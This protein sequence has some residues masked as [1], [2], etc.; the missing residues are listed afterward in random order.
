MDFNFYVVLTSTVF[1]MRKYIRNIDTRHQIKIS[2][3]PE[4][5]QSQL[6]MKQSHK[7]FC[8]VPQ[9]SSKICGLKGGGEIRGSLELKTT[10][11]YRS[12]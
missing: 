8:L 2:I 7:P 3:K 12:I 5:G 9:G 1:L 11:Q 10:V 6:A 4:T